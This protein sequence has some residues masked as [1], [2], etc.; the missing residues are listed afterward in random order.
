MVNLL[1][2]EGDSVIDR[3][4]PIHEQNMGNDVERTNETK[5]Y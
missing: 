5:Y 1:K 4:F 3:Y 2:Y